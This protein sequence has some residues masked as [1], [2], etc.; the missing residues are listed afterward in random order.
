[1]SADLAACRQAEG[2]R[3]IGSRRISV[4]PLM[5][6]LLAAALLKLAISDGGRDAS[7]LALVQ[8]GV[9]AATAAVVAAGAARGTSLTRPIVVLT[10]ILA[11][12]SFWSVR[13]DSS[14]REF[15]SWAAYLGV[16]VLVSSTVRTLTAARR[17]LDALV[18][19]AGW[20]GLVGLYL[21]WGA[22]DSG[23]RWYSTFYWP[24][25][26]AA[27]LLL[28]IPLE[29][30]RVVHAEHARDAF[31]HAAMVVLLLVPFV[32][33]YSR[34]AWLSL[35]GISLLALLVW[36]PASWAAAFRR[37][38]VTSAVTVLLV[39]LLTQGSAFRSTPQTVVGRAVS[40]A[41]VGD[42]SI[43]GRLN[44]WRVG[45]EIF[46]AHPLVGT[47]PGTYAR[48]SAAYQRDIRYF[49]K[50]AHS[51]YVQ[52]ASELGLIG[53]AVLGWLLIAL[54]VL[55]RR[56]L[57]AGRGTAEYPLVAGVALG[58]A[59]FF[60]HSALDMDW[61]YP[62]NGAMAFALMGVLAGWDSRPRSQMAASST[63][64]RRSGWRMSAAAALL[65][66]AALAQIVYAADRRFGEGRRLALR[67][68]WANAASEF[69]L[70][71]R[72]NP[73]DPKLPSALADALARSSPPQDEAAAALVRRSMALDRRNAYYPLQLARL[74][75][76]RM[77][78]EDAVRGEAMRL[79][80]QALGLDPFHYP[81]G[82]ALLARL[83]I[84]S[85]DPE[86]AEAVYRRA[87][88]T[89]PSGF[90]RDGILRSMLWPGVAAL[91]MDWASFLRDE[92]RLGDALSVYRG[93]LA[94]DPGYVPAY[95]EGADVLLR[96]RRVREASDFLSRGLVAVPASEAL[97]VKWRTLSSDRTSVQEE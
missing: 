20:V 38:L 36:R 69:R 93:I 95:L 83:H 60:A 5:P 73:L 15:T 97:W 58:V 18:V 1:M 27:F 72:L 82:Y 31:A 29:M 53:L 65:C 17:F 52:M 67:G 85:G 10:L 28:F 24:N 37:L 75:S 44:F 81:D 22:A 13:P 4:L 70:G 23:M 25:P 92:E 42:Y 90:A 57:A 3:G 49:A 19:I 30:A 48:V 16:F 59:A 96:Q 34:G 66:V 56:V 76:G 21:F 7:T 43:Q 51:L 62:V 33:T 45:L 12:A 63:A 41:N 6:V 64:H 32:L 14:V 89:Y 8:T 80:E 94:E 46:R 61:Q 54:V 77:P 78:A 26:F 47:G 39:A 86:A 50:D 84:E 91:Y 55:A 88:A 40:V 68:Q 9:L 74:L 2:S 79:T 71:A 11:A 87:G 35:A